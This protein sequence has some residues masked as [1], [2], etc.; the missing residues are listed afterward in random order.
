MRMTSEIE[1]KRDV[2]P[3]TVRISASEHGFDI[4]DDRI[5][6]IAERLRDLFDLAAPLQDADLGDLEPGEPFDPRWTSEERA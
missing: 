3:D 2:T 6:T 4:P 5:D 1:T